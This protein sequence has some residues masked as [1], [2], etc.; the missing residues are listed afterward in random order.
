[1]ISTTLHMNDGYIEYLFK[2]TDFGGMNH[3]K[4]LVNGCL[5]KMVGYYCGHT[6]ETIM[7]KANLITKKGNITKLGKEFV[8]LNLKDKENDG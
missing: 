5:K 8:W 1:M 4:L 3:R 6:L 7:F 2:G